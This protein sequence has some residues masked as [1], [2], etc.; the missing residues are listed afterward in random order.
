[1]RRCE[2]AAVAQTGAR[3]LV[4]GECPRHLPGARGALSRHGRRGPGPGARA[5]IARVV[6]PEGLQERSVLLPAARLRFR[7]HLLQG[8]DRQ[9][10]GDGARGR[11]AAATGGLLPRDRVRGRAEGDVRDVAQVLPADRGARRVLPGRLDHCDTLLTSVQA[12]FGGSFDPVHVGHLVAAETVGEAL[13]AGVRFLPAREQPLK[14]AVHAAHGASPE[15]RAEM[16]ELAVAGNPRLSVE[17]IE[18]TLP[19]P[20]Y[21]VR[22]LRALPQRE[23]GNRFTLLLG[24][25]AAAE[26]GAWFE[27]DAL[28]RLADVV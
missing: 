10:P 9:L 26:L 18:L 22:T 24:A 23:P 27:I 11:R 16:L 14:R 1:R 13:D 4:R 5:A 15:Q 20:S 6:R 21:T 8:R 2:P 3:P 7:H 12:L 25:D 28:P 19:T 17:R